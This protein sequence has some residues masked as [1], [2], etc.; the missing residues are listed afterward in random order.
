MFKSFSLFVAAAM[1][2]WVLPLGSFI[3]PSQ[4]ATACG[5]KRAM[6][7]CSMMS[8]KTAKEAPKGIAFTSASSVEK[9]AKSSASGGD[10]FLL[11]RL[12]KGARESGRLRVLLNQ[13]SYTSF[14]PDIP[15]YPPR[16]IAR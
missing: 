4:E 2:A 12:I 11:E 13:A 1:T 14:T 8:G 3:K 5:G 10:D 7:M 9:T 16:V 6:H 15:E